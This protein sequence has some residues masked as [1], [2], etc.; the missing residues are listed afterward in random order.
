MTTTLKSSQPSCNM[1]IACGFRKRWQGTCRA[2]EEVRRRARSAKMRPPVAV[3]ADPNNADAIVL[4]AILQLIL[5]ANPV[6]ACNNGRLIRQALTGNGASH[7]VINHRS[8]QPPFVQQHSNTITTNKSTTSKT[9]TTIYTASA[10]HDSAC[11]TSK[12]ST[13]SLSI[14]R[15]C[16]HKLQCACAGHPLASKWPRRAG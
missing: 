9:S 13:R 5:F 11:Q 14:G 7:T 10:N 4:V 12:Q 16:A 15:L 8:G 3:A 2:S 1:L 6:L